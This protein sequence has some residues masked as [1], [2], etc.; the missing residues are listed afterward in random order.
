MQA[1]TPNGD[2]EIRYQEQRFYAILRINNQVVYISDLFH[3]KAAAAIA[4]QA[5][6]E[7]YRNNFL[8]ASLL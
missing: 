1:S 8:S 6:N 4:A 2:I 7:R 3:S 5:M